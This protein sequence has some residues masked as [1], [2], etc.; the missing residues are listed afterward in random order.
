[1]RLTDRRDPNPTDPPTP[2]EPSSDYTLSINGSPYAQFSEYGLYSGY[3]Y[4]Y[5]IEVKNS[6]DGSVV[7]PS[8]LTYEWN[9]SDDSKFS[10]TDKYSGSLAEFQPV[11]GVA[12]GDVITVSCTV[13][14]NGSSI[15]TKSLDVTFNE[16]Y[17]YFSGNTSLVAGSTYDLNMDFTINSNQATDD[18]ISDLQFSYSVPDFVSNYV[19][20]NIDFSTRVLHVTI[21]GDLPSSISSF[22]LKY[23]VTNKSSEAIYASKLVSR[24]TSFMKS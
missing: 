6:S 19:T 23:T 4:T 10:K 18:E 8:T 12:L 7:D 16:Y 3:T 5:G 2:P 1:M 21:S 24:D 13:N 14:K 17:L 22:I 11:N 15:G 20:A 9:V